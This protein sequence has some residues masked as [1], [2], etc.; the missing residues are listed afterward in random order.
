MTENVGRND[1]VSILVSVTGKEVHIAATKKRKKSIF[2]DKT[3]AL[4]IQRR[5]L[6]DIQA[7]I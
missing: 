1:R 7:R 4:M 6:G 5:M 2:I 3:I